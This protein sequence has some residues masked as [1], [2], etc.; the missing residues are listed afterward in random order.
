MSSIGILAALAFLTGG[1]GDYTTRVDNAWWPMKPGTRWVYRETEGGHTQRVT[2][3]VTRRAKRVAAGI[4]ALVVHDLVTERGRWVE[5]TYDWYAQ[6]RAGNVWYLG[7]D[8]TEYEDGEAV[9]R[10]GSWEAGVDGARAGIVMPAHPRVGMGYRQ[11]YYAGHAEDRARVLSLDEQAGVPF[12]HFAHVL[13]T[14]DFTRLEPRV[15]E[16][17]FYARGVGPV[18]TLGASGGAG[19]EELVR[20]NG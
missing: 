12:G 11:E 5:N 15:V 16:Y 7:E 14:K 10:E 1:P 13:M 3:T 17:K 19:R 8:T 6:D 20:F 4:D 9:S 18:L 2:V